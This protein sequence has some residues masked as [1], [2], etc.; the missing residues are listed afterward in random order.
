VQHQHPDVKRIGLVAGWGRYR[1]HLARALKDVGYE[2]VCMGIRDHAGPVLAEICDVFVWK[3]MGKFGWATRFFR[4]HDVK[5][6]TLAGKIQKVRLYD[7][8]FIWRQAPDLYTIRL[9]ADHF[10]R[11]RGQSGR[12]GGVGFED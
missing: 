2:V 1:I 7:P 12:D 9:F 10:L 6:A 8:L 3:G 4:K 11:H 5:Y